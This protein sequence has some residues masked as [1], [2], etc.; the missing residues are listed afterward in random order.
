[1]D[2]TSREKLITN[3]EFEVEMYNIWCK[4]L[5]SCDDIK[6]HERVCNRTKRVLHGVRKMLDIANLIDTEYVY[7][8][9]Y[10]DYGVYQPAKLIVKSRV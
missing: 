9:E 10:Y 5:P 1:M 4:K 3:I 7:T 8:L 6:S 2:K